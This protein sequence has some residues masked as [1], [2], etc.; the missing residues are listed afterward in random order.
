VVKV[1][2]R[3]CV[4][5]KVANRLVV[6]ASHIVHSLFGVIAESCGMG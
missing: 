2:D 1:V 5:V 3:S 6:R 4:G